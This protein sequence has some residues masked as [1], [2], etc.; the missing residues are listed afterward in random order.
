MQEKKAKSPNYF[1]AYF[2][3]VANKVFPNHTRGNILFFWSRTF[4]YKYQASFQN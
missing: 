4:S 3:P 1:K 2:T